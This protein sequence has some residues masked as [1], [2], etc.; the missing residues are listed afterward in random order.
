MVKIYLLPADEG[1]FIWL[2]YGKGEKYAN[3]I[4][5][6]GTKSSGKEY[7]EVIENIAER[8]EKVEALVLPHIDYDLKLRT[9]ISAYAP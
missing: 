3:I 6:G 4:V 1:N 8:G 2:R 5:D 9:L 7:A